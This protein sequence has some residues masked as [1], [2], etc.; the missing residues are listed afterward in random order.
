MRKLLILFCF[1]PFIGY[2]GVKP[3]LNLNSP[4]FLRVELFN[5]LKVLAPNNIYKGGGGLPRAFYPWGVAATAV[6]VGG[7]VAYYGSYKENLPLAVTGGI[8]AIAGGT[9]AVLSLSPLRKYVG[10][11]GISKK[12]TKT[13]VA[14]SPNRLYVTFH[15]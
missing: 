15:F 11:T 12:N 5:N 9:L 10:L 3:V 6:L 14:I 4:N 13:L 1:V 7:G 2:S 8:V